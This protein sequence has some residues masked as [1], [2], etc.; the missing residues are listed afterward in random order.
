MP[1][2][3]ND[4]TTLGATNS[5]V[6]TDGG[7]QSIAEQ[8]GNVPKKIAEKIKSSNNILVALSRDP[9]VDA[10]DGHLFWRNAKYARI[11]KA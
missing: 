8:L 6:K 11:L 7:V 3:N 2:D 4:R 10:C 5:P 1:T 9:N